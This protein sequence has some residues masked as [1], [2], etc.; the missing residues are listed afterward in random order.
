M[1]QLAV[2]FLGVVE[3]ADEIFRAGSQDLRLGDREMALRKANTFPQHPAEN[4]LCAETWLI[5]VGDAMNDHF[6]QAVD[7]RGMQIIRSH[8]HFDAA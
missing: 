3:D 1:S 5:A 4:I 6:G 7:L 2:I 8:K